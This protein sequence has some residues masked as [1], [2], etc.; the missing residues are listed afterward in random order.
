[1]HKFLRYEN[2]YYVNTQHVLISLVE[3]KKYEK[4]GLQMCNENVVHYMHGHEF[5]RY[6]R[7]QYQLENVID[8]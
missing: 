6:E 4:G 3:H 5:L 1:M 7:K 2:L 8:V